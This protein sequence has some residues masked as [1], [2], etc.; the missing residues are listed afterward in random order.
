MILMP[1]KELFHFAGILS[2]P[3]KA[4]GRLQELRKG[5]EKK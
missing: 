3:G 1:C 5:R 4:A 2:G